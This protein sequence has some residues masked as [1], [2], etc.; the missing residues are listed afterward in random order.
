MPQYTQAN[1][2]SNLD[3]MVHGKV[4]NLVDKQV[5]MNRAVRFVLGDLDVRSAKRKSVISPNLFDDVYDYTCPTDLKGEA[6]IDILPQINRSIDSQIELTTEE[7][8]DRKKSFNKLMAAFSDNSFVRK[9]RLS[10]SIDDDQL[11]IAELDALTS[12]GGTWIGFGDGENLTVDLDNFFK[13]NGSINWDIS[14]A[15]GVTAGIQ[16]VGLD[17]F[18]I[19]DYTPAG[20]AFVWVYITSITDITNFILR[21]GQD[22]SNYK[23]KTVTVTNEGTA[24][25]QGWNLLRFDL[26]SLTTVG[27]PTETDCDYVALY[28]TKAAG[29]ISE[30]DYRFDW[31][32]LK[33]GRIHSVLYYS[34]YGWQTSAGV[35]IENSTVTTD[36]LNV[37]TEEFELISIKAAEF[38]AQ[39]LK[40]YDDWKIHRE[41]YKEK[42]KSYLRSTPSEAKIITNGYYRFGTVEGESQDLSRN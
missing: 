23:S 17:P 9:L 19:D 14:A 10:M 40:D 31:L 24:F 29:K 27:A 28:M 32:V 12:G 15:G 38:A 42:R 25:V 36:L 35:Y 37:D 1:L 11:L 30:T 5:T 26:Q 41:D 3:G 39:E 7:E 18:D 20:S 6:L 33:R 34:K 2:S 16:N 13:G 22:A 21:I 8:F 4:S